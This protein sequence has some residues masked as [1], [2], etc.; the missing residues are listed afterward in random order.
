[1]R[2]LLSVDT[3]AAIGIT[4]LAIIVMLGTLSVLNRTWAEQDA[5]KTAA[6]KQRIIEQRRIDERIERSRQAVEKAPPMGPRA[7]Q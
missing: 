4:L 7:N 5:R 6:R 3:T 2:K 1:M